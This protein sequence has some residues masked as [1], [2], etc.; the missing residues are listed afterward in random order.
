MDLMDLEHSEERDTFQNLHLTNPEM[1]L[2]P[3]NYALQV[4]LFI[5]LSLELPSCIL[6]KFTEEF[7]P[8]G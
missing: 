4:Q 6:L 7:L 8:L 5:I 3:V 1:L 2:G